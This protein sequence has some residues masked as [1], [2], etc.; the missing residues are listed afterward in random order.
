[1][2]T[3]KYHWRFLERQILEDSS[4][5]IRMVDIASLSILK[6]VPKVLKHW[7]ACFDFKEKKKE[8]KKGLV[9]CSG[10]A[11]S[12][13]L[14]WSSKTLPKFTKTSSLISFHDVLRANHSWIEFLLSTPEFSLSWLQGWLTYC[15]ILPRTLHWP[16]H[17]S[18]KLAVLCRCHSWE[19]LH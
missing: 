9:S 1:M 14:Q 3:N 13:G 6:E 18:S 7:V 19:W 5:V 10:C 16:G 2:Q 11:T 12:M 4:S 15:G 8:K 17:D